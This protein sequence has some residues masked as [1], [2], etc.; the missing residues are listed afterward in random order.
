MPRRRRDRGVFKDTKGESKKIKKD[1]IEDDLYDR[2]EEYL[3]VSD[4]D[5]N[6]PTSEQEKI[7]K[8]E[9]DLAKV[10]KERTA[11]K[12]KIKALEKENEELK[13]DYNRWDILDL[14]NEL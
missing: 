2:S 14:R 7:V 1:D 6:V 3:P 11:L 5:M 4:F 9:K 12:K 10:K 13:E 8:L